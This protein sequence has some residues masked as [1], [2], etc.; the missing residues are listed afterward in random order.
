MA[1]QV[2]KWRLWQADKLLIDKLVSQLDISPILGRILVNRGLIDPATARKFLNPS[3]LTLTSPW[4]IP[5]MKEAVG[6]IQQA[7]A[8]KQKILVYG[9]YDVDGLT[10]TAL[11]LSFLQEAG[12]S[13]GYYIPHRHD[14]GYGLNQEAIKWAA[15]EGYQLI[16]TVDCGISNIKEIELARELGLSIVVTDHHNI[17]ARLPQVILVDPKFLPPDHPAYYLAGVGVAFK[18][19]WALATSAGQVNNDFT[20]KYLDLVVLGTVADVVPLLAENR[21]LATYGLPV[22][23]QGKRLGLRALAAGAGL[24]TAPSIADIAFILGP[25]LN[26]A[27][28]LEHADISLKLL[29]TDEP[30]QAQALARQLNQLNQ[31]RQSTGRA[32]KETTEFWLSRHD[33]QQEKILI[34]SGQGWHPGVIGIVA[35]QLA[36]DYTRPVVLITTNGALAR[37]SARSID[38]INIFQLLSGCQDFLSQFG[39]HSQAAGFS[40]PQAA[41]R[42]FQIKLRQNAQ[43]E[44]A[45]SSLVPFLDIDAAIGLADISSALWQEIKRLAPFG[46]GN[47]QPS[48]LC[49]QTAVSELRSLSAGQHYRLRLGEGGLAINGVAFRQKPPRED[50][51]GERVDLVFGLAEDDHE[52]PAELICRVQDLS[53]SGRRP[54]EIRLVD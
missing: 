40:L 37:G 24:K 32:I 2:K 51:V 19:V 38:G 54:V 9:D 48:F 44:I 52:R 7:M 35:S 17:P 30:R 29:L 12:V 13:C 42:D 25:R 4:E 26:A 49:R 16:V 14:E 33:W 28:R 45:E 31:R 46:E 10:A 6:Q 36:D 3:L 5:G 47:A 34:F 27:G 50:L 11:L 15:R 53:L 41:V 8:D 22:L 23:A 18:L 39:G 21:I 1:A 43:V 20:M